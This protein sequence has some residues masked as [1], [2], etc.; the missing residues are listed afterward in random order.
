M[1]SNWGYGLIPSG[2]FG[3]IEKEFDVIFNSFFTSSK[4][5]SIFKSAGYPVNYLCKKDKDG[6]VTNDIL[7]I[8]LAGVPKENIKVTIEKE[9]NVNYLSVAVTK[10]T[11]SKDTYVQ[12]TSNKNWSASYALSSDHDVN[13]VNTT[14][15]DGLLTIDVPCLVIKPEVIQVE[16]K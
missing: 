7:E 9:N 8:A 1:K 2:A 14:L 15:K 10:R 12:G 4:L 3:Q 5:P 6:H 11:E 16:I 13:N